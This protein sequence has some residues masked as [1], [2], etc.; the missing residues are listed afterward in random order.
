MDEFRSGA[1][2]QYLEEVY[3]TE[4]KLTY[5]TLH[6]RHLLNQWLH[7]QMSGQGPYYGQCGWFS[8]L[9]HEKLPSAIERYKNEVHRI[10]G[11]LNTALE[12][13]EW[14][15]GD[16]C[17]FVDLAFLPW[18]TQLHMVLMTAPGED[19]LAAYPNVKAWHSRI[20]G[21]ES[22]KKAAEIRKKLMDEQQIMANGM[23]KGVKNVKEYEELIAKTAAE[24]KNN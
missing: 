5:H 21:R 20:E 17:T 4:K 18:N 3:D 7:F 15:V 9:H 6:E 16:K 11:V 13:K 19:P 24:G 1:I 10:L 2:L 12:S 8:V 23:P 14:L 22:W